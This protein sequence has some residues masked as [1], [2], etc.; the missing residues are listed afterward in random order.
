MLAQLPREPVQKNE[1]QPLEFAGRQKQRLQ[2]EPP[3]VRTQEA[4]DAPQE[5]SLAALLREQQV[6][7]PGPAVSPAQPAP[8]RRALLKLQEQQATQPALPRQARPQASERTALQ[9]V[10]AP[11][12]PLLSAV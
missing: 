8:L 12:L 6:S 9:A 1:A 4:L 2:A 5:R 11:A 7:P 3:E 10:P